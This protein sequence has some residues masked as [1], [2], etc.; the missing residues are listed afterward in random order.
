[1]LEA[2]PLLGHWCSLT[3]RDVDVLTIPEFRTYCDWINE[4]QKKEA[5]NRQMGGR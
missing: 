4:Q 1:M 5:E 2:L 3:A